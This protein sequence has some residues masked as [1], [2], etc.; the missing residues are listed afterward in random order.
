MKIGTRNIRQAISGFNQRVLE[1]EIMD[2]FSLDAASHKR[3]L[4]GLERI[5]RLSLAVNSFWNPLHKF[6]TSLG[7]NPLRILDIASGGGDLTRGLAL[8]ALKHGLPM[9]FEGCDFNPRAVEYAKSQALPQHVP[10]SYFAHD[11]LRDSIPERFDG[12]ISSLFL[13]HLTET[14]ILTFFKNVLASKAQ[15][16]IISDLNRSCGSWLLTWIGTRLLS[17]SP[18]VHAD[19]PQSVRAAL[20]PAEMLALAKQAGLTTAQVRPIWPMRYLLTYLRP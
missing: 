3:A 15:F 6:Y 11:A 12:V 4:A 20:R 2:D 17:S 19:G 14:E 9:T 16:L 10:V 13:H 7:N 1:P 18:V 8:K 5:N